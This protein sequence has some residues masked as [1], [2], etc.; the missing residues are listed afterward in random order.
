MASALSITKLALQTS[1]KKCISVG[2]K[3]SFYFVCFKD[4]LSF[5]PVFFDYSITPCE[6]KATDDTT[7]HWSNRFHQYNCFLGESSIW[8]H[9]S[10]TGECY[11][12]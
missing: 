6:C 4:I 11:T 9:V 5:Q 10:N 8:E 12:Q 2:D 1:N 7:A 3:Y